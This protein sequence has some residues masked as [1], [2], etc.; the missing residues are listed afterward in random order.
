MCSFFINLNNYLSVVGDIATEMRDPVFYRWHAFI[1]DLFQEHKE[2]LT[3]YTTQQLD[4]PGVI[5]NSA[6]VQ[7]EEGKNGD[8]VLQTFWQQT[9]VDF[10]RGLDFIPRGNVFA[11]YF[12]TF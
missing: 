3:P 8:S 6:T 7:L 1:D 2:R 11:R 4:F 12:L 9:D 5:V 10:S